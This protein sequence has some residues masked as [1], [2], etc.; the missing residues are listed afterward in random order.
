M[1]RPPLGGAWPSRIL[2]ITHNDIEQ[3][4]TSILDLVK[5]RGNIS[6]DYESAQL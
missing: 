1:E 6:R 5:N 3:E 4:M 2:H